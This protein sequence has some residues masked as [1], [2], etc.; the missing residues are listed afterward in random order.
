MSVRISPY[1]HKYGGIMTVKGGCVMPTSNCQQC[2]ITVVRRGQ[3]AGRFCSLD[4]KSAWQRT[5]KPVGRDWLHQKYVVEGWSTYRIG[6]EVG[7]DPKRVYEWLTDYGIP[8]RLRRWN[9]DAGSSVLEDPTW[10]QREY[11]EKQR[12]TGEIGRELGMTEANVIFF[13]RKH[14]IKRRTMS[15]ARA[16]KHWG[17]DGEKN[18]MFGKRGA[19]APSW[20]GGVTPERQGFYTSD[21]W[22]AVAKTIWKR[23][24]GICQRCHKKAQDDP[25]HA[26]HIHHIV[27][28]AVRELRSEASNLVLLC[29]QCHRWVHSKKNADRLFLGEWTEKGGEG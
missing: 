29:T 2:G 13:L 16:V 28:F 26:F 6:R 8:L 20:K 17:A 27:S 25:G 14:G 9:A 15:E 19:E 18:P 22:K 3:R 12:S 4:C 10:L 24:R 1:F 11:V 5:Q 7:R 21:E 23:D